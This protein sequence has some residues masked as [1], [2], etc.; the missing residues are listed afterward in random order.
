M[1]HLLANVKKKNDKC[2]CT[3]KVPKCE[4]IFLVDQRTSRK[5]GIGGIDTKTTKRNV[6]ALERKQTASKRRESK[7]TK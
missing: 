5:M 1:L 3:I 6:K 2:L 7:T 4:Q